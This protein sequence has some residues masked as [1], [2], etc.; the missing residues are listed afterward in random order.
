[1]L[2][3]LSVFGFNVTYAVRAPTDPPGPTS[4]SAIECRLLGHCNA[5]QDFQ[6]TPAR[7]AEWAPCARGP[8]ICAKTEAP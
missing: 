3:L 7:I 8:P 1:A 6:V 4:C 2:G 5:R